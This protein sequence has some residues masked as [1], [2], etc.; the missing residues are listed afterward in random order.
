MGSL[1][2]AVAAPAQRGV[3]SDAGARMLR[4]ASSVCSAMGA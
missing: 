1:S 4:L 2:G 3:E